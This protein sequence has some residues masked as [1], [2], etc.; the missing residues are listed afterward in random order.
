MYEKSDDII[1]QQG[2]EGIVERITN[3]PPPVGKI[4]YLPHHT[5]LRVA[6]DASQ[7]GSL[8]TSHVI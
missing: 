3:P 4:Y 2:L 8:P 5:K 7:K 1:R 6:Y